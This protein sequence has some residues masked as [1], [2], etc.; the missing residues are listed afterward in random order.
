MAMPKK[1]TPKEE[2]S[3]VA[4]PAMRKMHGAEGAGEYGKGGNSEDCC[5]SDAMFFKE[6]FARLGR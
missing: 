3:E 4:N 6:L 2:A 5:M 1:S